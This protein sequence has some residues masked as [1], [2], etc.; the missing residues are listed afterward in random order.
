VP[1][2]LAN[3]AIQTGI[4]GS[5]ATTGE[6]PL[7]KLEHSGPV[8]LVLFAVVV[9][10][11]WPVRRFDYVNYDDPDY[12]TANSHVQ[13]GLNWENVRW[14]FTS[15]HAS[16]WHPLT[17]LSHMLDWQLFGNAPGAQ[18]LVSVGFHA[19]NTAL[20]FLVLRRMTGAHWRS[21]LV[22]G[23]FGLHPLRAESV[24]WISERKDVVSGFFLL[25]MVACYR[26]YAG[27][28]VASWQGF[29]RGLSWYGLCL[30]CFTLGLTSKPMLV[31]VPFL[32]LLLDFWPFGRFGP[33][34]CGLN[35]LPRLMIEKIPFF[36]LAVASSV[37]TFL[38][39]QHGGAVSTGL[40]FT[41]RAANALVSY[42]R[43]LLKTV[44]PAD[45]SVLYPHPGHWPTWAVIGSGL[46]LVIVSFAALCESKRRPYFT[47]GWLW[48]MGALVPVIGLVQ[49]GIQSMADRY[50]Y[51]PCIGLF[52]AVVW[53][54]AELAEHWHLSRPTLAFGSVLV[55]MACAV[56]CAHQ[57]QFWHD[58]RA[59]FQRAI[60][61]TSG[62]YLAYNN[63]GFYL[64][65]KGKLEQ[66]KENYRKSIAINPAYPDALNNLGYALA[67]EGKYLEAIPYYETALRT[68]PNHPD[69]RNNLGNALSEVGRLNEAIQQYELAL[70][71]KPDHADAQ[72]DL[73]IALAMQGKLEEALTHFRLAI[74]ARPNYAGAHSNLG[75]ALAAE[76]KI[77]EAI[78]EYQESLRLNPNDAQAHNN[79]GNALFEQGRVDESIQQYIEALKLNPN[80]P[81]THFNLAI[82]L[83]KQDRKSEAAAHLQESLR[84]SPDNLE[85]QR[86][87]EA[88]GQQ[89]KLR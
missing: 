46:L 17:W 9:L 38:V 4:A 63:L 43:Y 78:A 27:F 69:I 77:P 51:I 32:L 81:Q 10:A 28:R 88:L 12:V 52:I 1:K 70:R 68:S 55:L 36:M 29:K 37:I 71:Q 22:A 26:G 57:I 86:Q 20:L 5:K 56:L 16:N 7:E 33:D 66:A 53:G 60:D 79:F 89:V 42:A 8:C 39:Q 72:N 40:P 59:L 31:S 11:F 6:S 61:V 21:A 14:A 82:A 50:T 87:L 3:K 80:N 83:S 44:W 47:T 24:A 73:G 15:G 48:F 25:L 30:I 35:Q 64:S 2:A 74:R 41:E 65:S 85:A 76:H 67:G 54:V 49:V 58:S 84:L 18:H 75:N 34:R 23:L 62:N 45:L 13:T 19:A